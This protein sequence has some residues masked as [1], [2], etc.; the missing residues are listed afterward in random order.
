MKN[1]FFFFEVDV[2]RFEKS[3]TL[4]NDLPFLL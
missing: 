1:V 4:H 3:H 2:Q